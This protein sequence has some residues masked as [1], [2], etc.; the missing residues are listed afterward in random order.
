MSLESR[1]Q[2]FLMENEDKTNFHSSLLRFIEEEKKLSIKNVLRDIK[3][4]KET[5]K[6]YG[7]IL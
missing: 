4:P 5:K 1:L 6:K 2:L 7:K 3:V